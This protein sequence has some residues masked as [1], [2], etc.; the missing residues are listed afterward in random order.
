MTVGCKFSGLSIGSWVTI[1]NE[2][3][4]EIIASAGYD[5]V[6]IDMEHSTMSVG[7]VGR[8]VRVVDACKTTPFVRVPSLDPPLVKRVLDAG[9][10]GVIFPDVKSQ[11]EA[12]IAVRS[13]HYPPNGDRGVG[14]ARAQG[15]GRSFDSYF[16]DEAPK[17]A[18]LIQIE[19]VS[20]VEAIDS[21]FSTDG[22]D[23]FII[24]PYDLSC[25]LGVPGDF[26]SEIFKSALA[27]VLA[28]AS[29]HNIPA[30]IHV[31]EPDQNALKQ[32][33]EE[34]YTI[35]A[36]SVDIRMLAVSADLGVQNYND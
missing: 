18:V 12:L 30:G 27:K 16:H 15:Y 3:V 33:I 17:T 23:G 7:D 35:I 10:R 19:S 21:I 25:S 24:G 34:G 11:D 5:W 6:V 1:G 32:R 20:A 31:V 28:A 4:A 29:K 13:V 22:I 26:E 2:T 9:A 36:Y 14:L 8:L